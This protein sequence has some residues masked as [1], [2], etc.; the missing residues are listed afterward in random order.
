MKKKRA[1]EQNSNKLNK[2][3]IAIILNIKL[4]IELKFR[5]HYFTMKFLHILTLN[6][7]LNEF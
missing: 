3:K 2:L 6:D 7:V 4:L 5:L 1:L